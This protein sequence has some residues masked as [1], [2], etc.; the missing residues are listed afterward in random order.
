MMLGEM[1]AKR[2]GNK[3]SLNRRDLILDNDQ[4]QA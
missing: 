4:N 3:L 1:R 2:K